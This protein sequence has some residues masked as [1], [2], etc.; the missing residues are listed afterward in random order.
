M[1]DAFAYPVSGIM[2]LWHLL[3]HSVLG[4]DGSIAWVLSLVG[5]VITVRGLITPFF[6]FQYKSGRTMALMMPELRQ[7]NEDLGERTDRSGAAE[8]QRRTRELYDRYNYKPLAGCVPPLIQIPAFLGLYRVIVRMARPEE[9]IDAEHSGIGFLNSDDVASFLETTVRDVPLP[10]YRTMD[11]ALLSEL[12]TT[13]SA[14]AHFVL[15]ILVLAVSFTTLNMGLSIFRNFEQFNWDSRSAIVMNRFFI[16]MLIL[17]PLM[18][19]NAGWNGPLPVAIVLYWFANNLWTLSQQ[20]IM[21]FF[22]QTRYPITD[23]FR[24][25]RRERRGAHKERS[26]ERRRTK[27]RRRGKRAL[28]FV[29]PWKAPALHRELRAEKKAHKKEK[30]EQKALKKVA[31]KARAQAKGRERSF[32]RAQ[33]LQAKKGLTAA[34]QWAGPEKDA[35]LIPYDSE[36]FLA[37]HAAALEAARKKREEKEAQA[38]AENDKAEAEGAKTT[39]ETE[40]PAEPAAPAQKGGRHRVKK[41]ARRTDRAQRGR[42]RRRG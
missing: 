16:G 6:W 18:L 23:E 20:A 17:M 39:G 32:M 7:I 1:L 38:K 28:M 29:A 27:W 15:P 2:K 14:V 11:P 36:K 13:S 19:F 41:S 8:H 40:A 31:A 12:G 42:H 34:R 4:L 30:A 24:A 25:F 37:M 35:T 33:K 22:L 5:L 21:Y 9:G 3:L 26:A 10:A